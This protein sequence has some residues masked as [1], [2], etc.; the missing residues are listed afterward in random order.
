MLVT[1]SVEFRSFVRSHGGTAW[2]R[3]RRTFGYRGVVLLEAGVA[4]PASDVD[5]ELYIV[6]DILVAARLPVDH[7]PMELHLSLEGRRRRRPVATWDGCL[8][9][10]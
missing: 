1:A 2:V 8:F 10:L 7:R 5:F 3:C 9:V 4:P 6:D